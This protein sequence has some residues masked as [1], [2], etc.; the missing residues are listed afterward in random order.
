MQKKSDKNAI[1]LSNAC[2]ICFT[3]EKKKNYKKTLTGKQKKLKPFA[4][5]GG[6]Q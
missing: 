4:D 5:K 6:K 1:H 3:L 2:M